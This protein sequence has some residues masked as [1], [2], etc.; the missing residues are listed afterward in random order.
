MTH[1]VPFELR[2]CS[3][4]HKRASEVGQLRKLRIK[5]DRK[6]IYLCKKHRNGKMRK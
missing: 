2:I 5:H 6:I 1:V 3:I 4:C